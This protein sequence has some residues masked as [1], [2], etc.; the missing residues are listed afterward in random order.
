MCGADMYYNL[1]CCHLN[2]EKIFQSS[3]FD[4][5][6][7]NSVGYEEISERIKPVVYPN[8]FSEFTTFIFDYSSSHVYRLQI[9]N[10]MG[11]IIQTIENINTGEVIIKRTSLNTGIH[12]YRLFKENIEIA[13]GKFVVK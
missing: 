9:I 2:G 11:Q 13:T 3:H 5:C 7:V 12:F 8:P 10:G 4:H 6:F 1:S